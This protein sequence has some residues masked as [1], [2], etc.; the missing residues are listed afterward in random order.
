MEAYEIEHSVN[1]LVQEKTM[2]PTSDMTEYSFTTVSHIAQSIQLSCYYV[3]K[4]FI[5]IFQL[6]SARATS[7]IINMSVLQFDTNFK[8]SSCIGIML[9]HLRK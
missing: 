5:S 6:S 8:V 9:K 3:D 7:P 2:L 4:F 1:L